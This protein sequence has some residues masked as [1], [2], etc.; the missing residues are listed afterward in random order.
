MKTVCIAFPIGCPRN[1]LDAALLVDF[2]RQNCW[3]ITKKINKANYIFVGNCGFTAF[4]EEKSIKFL[5]IA[6]RRKKKD[7]KLFTFGCLSGINK[8]RIL[9][10]S[11]IIPLTHSDFYKLETMINSEVKISQLDQSYNLDKYNSYLKKCFNL[12]DYFLIYKKYLNLSKSIKSVAQRINLRKYFRSN[13]Q[14]AHGELTVNQISDDYITNVKNTQMDMRIAY[15][16]DSA[17]TYCAIKFA[18]GSLTS[19]PIDKIINKIETGLSNGYK[20]FRLVAEDLGAYGQDT[21]TNIVELLSRI[22]RLSGNFKIN[23]HDFSP[24]WLIQYFPDLYNLFTNNQDK[25]QHLGL[26]IQSGSDRILKLMKRDYAAKDA[27]R[28]ISALKNAIPNLA[29]ITHVLIGFPGET[30]KD[31]F[32]TL[33][34]LDEIKFNKVY[35]YKYSDR[36]NCPSVKFDAKVPEKVKKKRIYQLQ[37]MTTDTQLVVDL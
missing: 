25:L 22:F 31:F 3:T 27:K 13:G 11:E 6:K 32:K 20:I 35:V 24:K 29:I 28:S 16:C 12:I 26:P 14:N 9:K 5:S 21:G 18:A 15:G 2:F 1:N 37:K 10:E 4:E 8:E 19:V 17:C 34:L 30:E 36:P 7:A 33:N 23:L